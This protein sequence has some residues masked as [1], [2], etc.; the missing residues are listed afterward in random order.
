M[1]LKE[2]KGQCLLQIQNLKPAIMPDITGEVQRSIR[3]LLRKTGGIF[4]STTLTTVSGTREY[5]IAATTPFPS[6]FLSVVSLYRSTIKLDFI[7]HRER[8]ESTSL[9][10]PN[11]YYI[12]PRGRGVG[13]DVIPNDAYSIIFNYYGLGDN[14]SADDDVVL[15][16]LCIMDDD[17]VWDAIVYDFAKRYLRYLRMSALSKRDDGLVGICTAMLSSYDLDYRTAK[18]YAVQALNDYNQDKEPPIELPEDYF[19]IDTNDIVERIS[20]EGDI[21]NT[22]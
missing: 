19:D 17:S 15:G 21:L 18:A 10:T 4:R 5:G 1:T 22:W 3:D 16:D 13:F 9:G 12:L 20:E 14:V 7:Y 11:S 2:L 8:N 6:D